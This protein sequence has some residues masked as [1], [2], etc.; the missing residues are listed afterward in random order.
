MEEEE[1]RWREGNKAWGRQGEWLENDSLVKK[2]KKKIIQIIS[3]SCEN[4]T[5]CI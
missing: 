5:Q 2:V 4:F 1:E 3:I